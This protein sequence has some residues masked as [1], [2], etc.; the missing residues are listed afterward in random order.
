VKS[1]PLFYS[2]VGLLFV[3]VSLPLILEKVGP[4][5]WYGLRV[6]KTLNDERIWYAANRVLGYDLLIA[7][8]VIFLTP[9]ILTLVARQRPIPVTKISLITLVIA[10][11]AAVLHSLASLQ[12]M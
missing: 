11:C 10:L 4:N 8:A 3:F 9:L 1:N 5:R 7:G 6:E 12:R 2:L